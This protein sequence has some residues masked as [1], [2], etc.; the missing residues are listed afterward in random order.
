[1]D[2][3]QEGHSC[4]GFG[5]EFPIRWKIDLVLFFTVCPYGED[6]KLFS[7]WASASLIDFALAGLTYSRLPR[8]LALNPF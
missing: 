6:T 5:M 2:P 7:L 1:M 4:R 3:D 8:Y